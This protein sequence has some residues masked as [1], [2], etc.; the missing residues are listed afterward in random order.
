MTRTRVTRTRMTR[1]RIAYFKLAILAIA[2]A[3]AIITAPAPA[4]AG[5]ECANFRLI[6]WQT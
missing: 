3:G 4:K 1:T 2:V 6:C 5:G